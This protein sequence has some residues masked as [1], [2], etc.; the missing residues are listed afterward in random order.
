MNA[1]EHI[2]DNE[3]KLWMEVNSI[4]IKYWVYV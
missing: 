2:H 3:P 1:S 4:F